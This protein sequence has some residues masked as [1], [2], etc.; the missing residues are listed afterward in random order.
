M[1][2]MRRSLSGGVLAVLTAGV[3]GC[4]GYGTNSGGG[5]SVSLDAYNYYFNPTS[6]SVASGG[7]VTINFTNKGSVQHNLTIEGTKV[8]QDVDPG[9]TVTVKF[10][11][12]GDAVMSF[13]C[14]YHQK[15]GMIGAI[16]IGSGG[17]APGNQSPATQPSS[18]TYHY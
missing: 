5:S 7:E 18:G 4:G 17:A 8:N 2:S 10:T 3:A 14:E 15:S 9:K 1:G 16:K 6:L 12:S 13:H 11:P